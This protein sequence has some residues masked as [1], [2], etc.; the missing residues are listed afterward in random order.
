MVQSSGLHFAINQ[1]PI[2]SYITIREKL[3]PREALSNSESIEAAD[4]VAPD[5][6]QVEVFKKKFKDLHVQYSNLIH[7]HEVVKKAFED[8][9][10]GHGATLGEKRELSDAKSIQ[11]KKIINIKQENEQLKSEIKDLFNQIKT[12]DDILR[13]M[14][15]GFT[16]STKKMKD[17]IDYLEQLKLNKEQEEKAKK[18]RDKKK[19]KKEKQKVKKIEA[20][21]HNTESLENA[22][23]DVD[24]LFRTA[25]A[26]EEEFDANNNDDDVVDKVE[27]TSELKHNESESAS[28]LSKALFTPF[29][30]PATRKVNLTLPG[31]VKCELCEETF[32]LESN[33]LEVAFKIHEHK[34][35]R[36][37]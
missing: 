30:V 8:E 32:Q 3:L 34:K 28:I 17:K 6:A 23:A 2:S 25:A 31:E 13:N 33:T 22:L 29:Q 21:I 1:T 27:A 37:S 9:I 11:D 5:D 20:N 36:H 7:S 26:T 4:Q 10:D 12:K 19:E 24:N 35:A 16:E 14:N 15:K 18:K